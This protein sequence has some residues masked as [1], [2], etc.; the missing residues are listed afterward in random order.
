M[1]MVVVGRLGRPIL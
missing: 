1:S